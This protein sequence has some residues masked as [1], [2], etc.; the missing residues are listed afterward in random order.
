MSKTVYSAIQALLASDTK[1]HP[2]EYEWRLIRR[3]G[4]PFMLLSSRPALAR[5]G[6]SLYSAQRR[7][8][9]AWRG[10]LPLLFQTPVG[11]LFERI[12][13]QADSSA[14]FVQFM[15]QQ[16]GVPADQVFPAAIK[17]SETGTRARLVL[18]LCDESARPT[19]V[20]KVGLGSAGRATADQEADFLAQLPSGKLG[21]T[22]MTGRLSAPNFSAFSMD[23][24]SGTS[25]YDDAGLEHLFHDWLNKDTTAPLESLAPWRELSA[26][27]APPHLEVWRQINFA[28][29]G[30]NIRTTLYHGDFAPWNVRVIN[31]RNL[32]VFD[33]ER[34]SLQGIPGWDWFH[35]TVQT[36]ILPRR[37][38]VERA[39]AEVDELINSPRFKKYATAA[40]I[41]D[42]IEPLVLA[43]LLH[44]VWV[45]KPA[46]GGQ[47]TA[48]LFD[49]LYELWSPAPVE[50]PAPLK[51]PAGFWAAGRHQ[52]GSALR[53]WSN[54][55]W[56]PGLNSVAIRS[57]RADFKS[58]W[59]VLLTTGLLLAAIGT[60][61]FLTTTH[62]MFLPFYIA[63]CGF[64]TWKMGRRWGTLAAAIAAAIAPVVV[65]VRDAGFREMEVMIW[66]TIMR[67]F[68]LQTC[69][70][71]V[72]RIH[73]QREIVHHQPPTDSR[74]VKLAENWMVLLACGLFFVSV[75][76]LDYLTDPH[77]IFLPLYLFPCM[78]LT[79]V[80]NLRWGIAA[81]I[82]ATFTCTWIEHLTDKIND[83][84]VGI[85]VWNFTMRLMIFLLVIL[86][87]H[88]IRKGNILFFNR[89]SKT[90]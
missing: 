10:I 60:A 27:V 85:F 20:I 63:T 32:Q 6:L 26:A 44:H 18:L 40:G 78:L 22:R 1:S 83:D 82:L 74:P 14:E 80:L 89:N 70:L 73:K 7:R 13:F 55:F 2:V 62:L 54:L 38:S 58:H 79:L 65:A 24:F 23:Y 41:N 29:A 49:L 16:A 4:R 50:L 66:N 71:F 77:L 87:L 25:P 64:L 68:I 43:Y 31:S 51:S 9:K 88:G 46:E 53:Q 30:K 56:E 47:R 17:L 90:N 48:A 21:C 37:L 19:R 33:W 34:G 8:A 76:V 39:A 57:G 12:H 69:V 45:I 72:D 59:P 28:L 84:F 61:H 75:W 3:R 81:A 11:G 5:S 42:I 35:F 86:L 52:L 36:S 67:F 15:A